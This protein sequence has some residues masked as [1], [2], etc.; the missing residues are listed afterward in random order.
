MSPDVDAWD[1]WHPRR[2]ADRLRGLDLPWYVAAGWAIDLFLGAPTRPHHDLEI[3][4]PAARFPEVAARFGEFEFHVPREGALHP[5]TAELLR[6]EH[7]TWAWEPVAGRWRF[8]VFREPHDGDTWICRRDPRIRLPLRDI[9][10]HDATGVPYLAPE[11]VLLFK[12][13]ATRPKDEAD[14]A[15][16]LPQ[17]NIRRRRW[18]DDALDLVHPAHPWRAALL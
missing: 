8:D 7:Q 15:H 4:V 2:M 12:A 17:M 13:K 14:F 6:D 18:L 16:A 11:I 1:A 5:V 3:A 9:I 10:E